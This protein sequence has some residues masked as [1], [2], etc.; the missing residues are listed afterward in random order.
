MSDLAQVA[1]NITAA[2]AAVEKAVDEAKA[3]VAAQLVDHVIA[4]APPLVSPEPV[5]DAAHP[6]YSFDSHGFLTDPAPVMVGDTRVEAVV[7]ADCPRTVTIPQT[8]HVLCEPR[9]DTGE[10][11]MR[12]AWRV[13]RQ[14][15]AVNPDGSP[16]QGWWGGIML[17]GDSVFNRFGGV[18]KD[19]SNWP[20]AADFY[21][22]RM[23][24][25]INPFL[26]PEEIAEQE[27]NAALWAASGVRPK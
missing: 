18:K 8:G 19:G 13:S 5:A 10:G 27:R 14:C 20:V 16:K 26:T 23:T 1:N 17:F 12:Y 22:A 2:F 7:G 4:T 6:A 9:P 24:G 25:D 15:G 21:F 11:F 3:T